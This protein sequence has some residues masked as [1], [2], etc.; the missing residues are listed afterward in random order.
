MS[1]ANSVDQV[2]KGVKFLQWWKDPPSFYRDIFNEEPYYYQAEVLRYLTK[3]NST[4]FD[5]AKRILLEAAGGTGKSK[6]LACIA[7]WLTVVVPKF[8]GRPYSVIIISGSEDQSRSL[9]AHSKYA[10]ADSPIINS[11]VEGDP[12]QSVVHFRD[13]SVILASPNSQKAIQGKHTDC[14]IVDEGALAGDF[15][16]NDT[17]RII[18]SSNMDLIIL[19]GTPMIFGTKFVELAENVDKYT[20]WTRFKWDAMDCPATKNKYEE[21]R[22][23][24]PEDLFSIFWE[25]KAYAGMGVMIPP[26]EL[27]E[28]VKDIQQFTPDPNAP[29]IAGVDWGYEHY[30][31]VVIIQR[32]KDGIYRVMYVDAWRREEYEDIQKKL[33]VTLKDFGVWNVYTDNEN[34]GENQRLSDQGFIVNPIVFNKFKV[35]MQS[36]LKVIFHQKKI[37]IPEIYNELVTELR[38]YNW[39]TK[40]HDDRVDALQLACW[41]SKESDEAVYDWE[42][43]DSPTILL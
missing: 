16:I 3:I 43:I 40:V 23:S 32:G 26:E 17:Y 38:K 8:I 35:Q 5:R 41:G 42:I 11:E 15:V 31:A 22:K 36:H 30:T 7:L 18:G 9:Y 29:L 24:L 27:R 14:A 2:Y 19:S 4:T 25:G 21:A 33:G 13:R 28:A 39:T 12:L 10:I 6:L 37:K 34:I 1:K 20:E